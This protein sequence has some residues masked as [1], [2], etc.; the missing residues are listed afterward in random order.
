MMTNRQALQELVR[1]QLGGTAT[2]MAAQLA[3]D[4]VLRSICDGLAEDG[5]VRLAHFGTFKVVQRAPRRLLLP[6]S[7]QELLLPQRKTVTF[8]EH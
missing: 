3:V 1:Q 7:Q 5:E 2:P 8:R 6:G 4:A